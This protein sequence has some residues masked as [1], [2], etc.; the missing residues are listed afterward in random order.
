ME[1][2][3]ILFVINTM[4]H[5]GAETAIIEVMKALQ[6]LG[7]ALDLYVMTGQ[8]ELI[9]RVPQGVNLINRRYNSADV[10]SKQ[11]K[12]VLYANTALRLLARFSG[13]R[14]VPY[15]IKNY[16]AMKKTGCVQPDKL[17]WKPIADG[18]GK[19][20]KHYNVAIA[21]T[22][23]AA[24]YYVA[25]KVTADK[26]VA[27]FHT[28]YKRSGYTRQLDGDCYSCYDSIFCVSDE[29]RKSFC[30]VYTEHSRKTD[31]FRNIIDADAILS[32]AK[33][34]G[35]FSDSFSGIRIMTLGRLVKAK[36]L[37]RSVDA[38]SILK[39]KGYNVRW[40]VFGEGE[41]RQSLEKQIDKLG[42]NDCFFLPGV[43]KTPFRYLRSADI[44][45]QCSE[46]EGQ[47]IAI[48]EA[49]VLGIPAVVSKTSGSKGEVEDGVDGIQT[50]P[51]AE[52][53]A[54]AIETLINNP[55]LRKSMGKTAAKKSQSD[56]DI[57]KLIRVMEGKN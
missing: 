50:T 10:L 21:Y 31:V 30:E 13:L 5:G 52:S 40:Y 33:E 8:G 41:E 48:R 57:Q 32:A 18:T 2:K 1:H 15:I 11:G 22:E 4:G 16:A 17:L 49:Q 42:L 3:S 51:D 39:S 44:Y 14:N 46:F 19:Q 53:I 36:A 7:Y 35:G 38:M 55:E 28:D 25:K 20:K 27:F 37:D 47:G 29:A 43:T 6:N 24:T 34:E 56:N 23:G 26:K 45:V 54:E 12:R 9:S